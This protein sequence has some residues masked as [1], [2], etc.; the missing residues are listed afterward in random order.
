MG[1]E[2][3]G[4]RTHGCVWLNCSLWCSLETI[5]ARFANGLYL[6]YKTE[7]KKTTTGDQ[8]LMK[9]LDDLDI[10]FKSTFW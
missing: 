9:T 2:F 6:K 4:E 1:G 8:T 5:T 10:G 3:G 7:V